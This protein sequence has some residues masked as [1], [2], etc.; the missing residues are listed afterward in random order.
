MST[1]VAV[2]ISI[3]HLLYVFYWYFRIV[4]VWLAL[5]FTQKQKFM[6]KMRI[7]CYIPVVTRATTKIHRLCWTKKYMHRRNSDER[8]EYHITSIDKAYIKNWE[9][10]RFNKTLLNFN[11]FTIQWAFIQCKHNTFRK[12]RYFNSVDSALKALSQFTKS[13]G[14]I[15]LI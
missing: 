14:K 2:S 7:K 5:S 10:S 3:P 4:L 6:L 8:F 9:L 15:Q 1:H 11:W 12:T 13:F